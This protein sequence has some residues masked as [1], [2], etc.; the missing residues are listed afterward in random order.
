M[1]KQVAI[2]L[3]GTIA[4]YDGFKGEDIIGDPLP[5]AR[6]FINIL[7]TSGF[8]IIIHTTRG[9]EVTKRW[10]EVHEIPY[11]FINDNPRIRGGN[12]GKPIAVAYVDDRAVNVRNKSWNDVLS[13]ITELASL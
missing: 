10:L 11:H 4:H 1:A 5:G 2:D 3:D 7:I 9:S 8:E 12:Q 13:E 6:E